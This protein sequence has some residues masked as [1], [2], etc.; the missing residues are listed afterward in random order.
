[1][2]FINL[3]TARLWR[4]NHKRKLRAECADSKR[5]EPKRSLHLALG[6]KTFVHRQAILN[7]PRIHKFDRLTWTRSHNHL[8][9]ESITLASA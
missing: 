5:A 6:I 1:M 7:D 9:R 4:R 2:P 8:Y 3:E